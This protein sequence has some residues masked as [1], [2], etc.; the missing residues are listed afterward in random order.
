MRLRRKSSQVAVSTEQLGRVSGA[1]HCVVSHDCVQCWNCWK[2][3]FS[4]NKIYLCLLIYCLISLPE[5]DTFRQEVS[6]SCLGNS[7][8][9]SRERLTKRKCWE[10]LKLVVPLVYSLQTCQQVHLH[11]WR[12]QSTR[13]LDSCLKIKWR[14]IRVKGNSFPFYLHARVRHSS[15]ALTALKEMFQQ[16]LEKNTAL[17]H[18]CFL[19]LAESKKQCRLPVDSQHGPGTCFHEILRLWHKRFGHNLKLCLVR[20]P[21]IH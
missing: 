11:I 21:Y 14:G 17:Y 1:Q 2:K 20:S 19:Y 9:S 16:W 5:L 6:S 18:T 13:L 7:I 10:K 15:Y 12:T 3:T 8:P 4:E